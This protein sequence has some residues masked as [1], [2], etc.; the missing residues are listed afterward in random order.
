M[1]IGLSSRTLRTIGVISAV[2]LGGWLYSTMGVKPLT[3]E[4]AVQAKIVAAKVE[5]CAR[6]QALKAVAPLPGPVAYIVGGMLSLS[7]PFRYVNC[8][9][10]SDLDKYS[11]KL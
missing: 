7:T 2:G 1:A 11:P 10:R 3:A 6:E 8:S 9:L 4:Q 5:A